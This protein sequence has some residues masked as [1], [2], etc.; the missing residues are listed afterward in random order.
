MR[1]KKKVVRS[2]LLTSNAEIKS[3]LKE[4]KKSG[5]TLEE[6]AREVGVASHATVINWISK[7]AMPTTKV[8]LVK[9]LLKDFN[10]K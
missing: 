2:N 7:K 10:G 8:E 1:K 5:L 6:I 3:V 4:L 9:K